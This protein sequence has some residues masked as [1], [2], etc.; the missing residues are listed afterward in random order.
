M[1]R[2]ESKRSIVCTIVCTM[3]IPIKWFGLDWVGLG[4]VKGVGR[5]DSNVGQ[6]D[7]RMSGY[8]ISV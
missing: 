8:L 7:A 6:S 4:G 2:A 5:V 3:I 1:K